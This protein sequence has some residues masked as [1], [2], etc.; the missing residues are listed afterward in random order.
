MLIFAR[1]ARFAALVAL[2]AAPLAHAQVEDPC[3]KNHYILIEKCNP[4]WVDVSEG[5]GGYEVRVI[6][7]DPRQAGTVYAGGTGGLFKSTD[8]GR[9]WS[10]T[11]LDEGRPPL[12]AYTSVVAQLLIDPRNPL[13]V[14]A[15]TRWEGPRGSQRRMLKSKDGGKT[16]GIEVDPPF[17]G[18]DNIRALVL[19]PSDPST[20][21]VTDFDDC[22]GDT[23]A[24]IARSTEAGLNWTHLPYR[25]F[26]ALAVDPVDALTVYGGTFAQDI[27]YLKP[28][29]G[30]MK[31]RDGGVT[32]SETGLLDR[33]V[34]LLAVQPDDRNVVYA[35]TTVQGKRSSDV[36]FDGLYK[37]IDSGKT[38]V[39][40]AEIEPGWRSSISSLVFDPLDSR[41]LYV[42]YSTGGV[43]R[44]ID[45]GSNW[46]FLGL[47]DLPI[48]SL[49]IAS[50]GSALYAG[51]PAGA[52]KRFLL[53]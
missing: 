11:G 32:W 43:F 30:V 33:G 14:Y 42:A 37:S 34:T 41:T 38:W 39:K 50:D 16:W 27:D 22:F 6:A 36:F 5:L 51:T 47:E 8:A 2:V 13:V 21:Y 9:T 23:W 19:A 28:R 26:Q 4:D 48:N 45:A 29:R 46:T 53:H 1:I 44:S 49:A 7:T 40:L 20:L 25:V 24:P 17:G 3:A 18:A 10:L 52:H 15:G 35:A 12:F 31:S